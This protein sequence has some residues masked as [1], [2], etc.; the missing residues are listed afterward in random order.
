M[1]KIGEAKSGYD[2]A[3]NLFL[4]LLVMIGQIEEITDYNILP[5]TWQPF[6]VSPS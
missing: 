5:A 1:E 4:L 6:T 2:I 3:I